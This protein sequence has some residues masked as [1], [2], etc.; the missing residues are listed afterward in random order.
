MQS[1]TDNL[2]SALGFMIEILRLSCFYGG[3]DAELA[4]VAPL[5]GK[6]QASIASSENFFERIVPKQAE[7]ANARHI[8]FMIQTRG[9]A[10]TVL[11]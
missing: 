10:V 6:V 9:V 2:A 5:A 11:R 4:Y 1:K 3:H 7:R 8:A